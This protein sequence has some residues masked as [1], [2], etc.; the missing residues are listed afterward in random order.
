MA[1]RK[2]DQQHE[3]Y[4]NDLINKY[5]RLEKYRD[6]KRIVWKCNTQADKAGLWIEVKRRNSPTG[7]WTT[8]KWLWGEATHLI[9]GN[10]RLSYLFNVEF[11]KK[12]MS[13]K[14][15]TEA[16]HKMSQGFHLTDGEIP[17]EV[18]RL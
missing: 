11:L 1:K 9:T 18:R 6:N 3:Q 14:Q 8:S 10:K 13:M 4:I 7:K 15:I 17:M 12:I 16:T 5:P 2:T